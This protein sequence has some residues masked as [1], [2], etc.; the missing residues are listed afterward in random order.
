MA[1]IHSVRQLASLADVVDEFDAFIIDQFGVLHDGYKRYD[2]AVAT[3]QM[4]VDTG[5]AVI[6]LSNSGKRS[7]INIERMQKL[8]FARSL[9]TEFV[10]SGD[11]AFATINAQF[12]DPQANPG[13][14][15]NSKPSSVRIKPGCLLIARDGDKSAVDGLA[16]T[17][18]DDASKAAF[19]VISASESD[20]F[21]EQYYIE[22]LRKAA[23]RQTPCLCTNPDKLMLTPHGIKFGAGRIAELYESLGGHVQ[24]IGK[25]YRDVYEHCLRYVPEIPSHRILC[26]G[27]SLEHDIAG[28]ARAALKTLLIRNGIHRDMDDVQ[29]AH[30][31][32]LHQA[33]PD[34]QMHEIG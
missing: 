17:L 5:K 29:L 23:E 13:R 10:S 15:Q 26:I 16:L 4:L 3:L 34:Y 7:H 25:P 22:V 11:V 30:Y 28:G 1:S 18:T 33:V 6:I 27:D 21:S 2:K 32:D 14:T 9:F 24:W 31:M 20:R 19:V 12:I 8:G